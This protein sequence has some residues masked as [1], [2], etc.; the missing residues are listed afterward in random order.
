MTT[1]LPGS[2]SSLRVVSFVTT[3]FF[4]PGSYS[5]AIRDFSF[6]EINCSS[7]PITKAAS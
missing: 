1:Y 4:V 7:S 2:S 5:S 3:I 6:S